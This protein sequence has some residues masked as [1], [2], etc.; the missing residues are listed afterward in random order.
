MTT[1]RENSNHIS[2]E[3]IRVILMRDKC[4]SKTQ[5]LVDG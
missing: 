2:L 1:L 5:N 4:R 3:T